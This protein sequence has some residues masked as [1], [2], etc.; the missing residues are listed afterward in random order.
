MLQINDDMNRLRYFIA[1]READRVN[2]D[3][4]ICSFSLRTWGYIEDPTESIDYPCLTS[5]SNCS[6]CNCNRKL[7]IPY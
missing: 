7:Q 4:K 5:T 3:R 6:D 2:S 1:T